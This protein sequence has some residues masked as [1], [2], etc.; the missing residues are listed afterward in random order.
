MPSRKIVDRLRAGD[1]LLMDGGTGTE[2]QKR[3]VNISKGATIEKR[4]TAPP[5]YASREVQGVTY[6]SV[7]GLGVWSAPANLEAPDV[8]RQVHEDYLKIGADIII[9]NTFYTTRAMLSKIG[10][11]DRWEQYARRAVALATEARARVNPEAYLAGGFAPPF[12]GDLRQEAE[13]VARV[14]ADAGVDFLLPEYFGGDTIHKSPIADCVTAVDACAKTGLPVFLGICNVKEDGTMLYGETFTELTK[15][16]SGHKV[17]GI[18]LMCTQPP[19]ISACLPKL[20]E[21][22]GGPVGAYAELGYEENPNFGTSP[23]EQFFVIEGKEYTPERYAAFALEWK[24]MGAQVIG[25]CCGTGP[26]HIK[27][28]RAAIG[29]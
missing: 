24:K 3:G 29:G 18:F 26:D 15:A 5:E 10:E 2:L 27:A 28:V 1:V 21:A 11:Q 25:G 22:Y 9:T 19:A 20:R 7:T 23:K 4:P 13:N 16:L 8:V 17:D 6:R 12:T 14:L